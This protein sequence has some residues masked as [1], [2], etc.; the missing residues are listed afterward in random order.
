VTARLASSIRVGVDGHEVVTHSYVDS[1]EQ[2]LSFSTR[3]PGLRIA[4][5]RKPMFRTCPHLAM[6][7]DGT[8]YLALLTAFPA[9]HRDKVR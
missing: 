4:Y 7:K 6:H 2:A 3:G 5:L 8:A 9:R 1:H